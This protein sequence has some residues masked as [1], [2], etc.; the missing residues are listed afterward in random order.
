MLP[1]SVGR[2]FKVAPHLRGLRVDKLIVADVAALVA[3]LVEAGCKQE[4]Y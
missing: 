3:A 2:I 1:S 4:T